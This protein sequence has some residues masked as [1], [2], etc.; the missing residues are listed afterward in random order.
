MGFF[1][2]LFCLV[3]GSIL[4]LVSTNEGGR[5]KKNRLC[6]AVGWF[7][8]VPFASALPGLWA[9]RWIS[10]T[11][12]AQWGGW[13]RASLSG[14]IGIVSERSRKKKLQSWMVM[15]VIIN[16]HMSSGVAVS[17]N[18]SPILAFKSVKSLIHF[19]NDLHCKQL[20]GIIQW[21]DLRTSLVQENQS[22]YDGLIM[23][24]L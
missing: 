4:F 24:W 5:V 21:N 10:L 18:W 14:A 17:N 11:A 3:S 8:V 6:L 7:V 12:E 1:F 23:G 19:S 16:G 9:W 13:G 15:F 20:D 22:G 2:F